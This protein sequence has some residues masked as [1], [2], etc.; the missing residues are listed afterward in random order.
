MKRSFFTIILQYVGGTYIYQ[1]RAASPKAALARW[2]KNVSVEE[3]NLY[4]LERCDLLRALR[5]D[6]NAPVAVDQRT[7]VWC[8]WPSLRDVPALINIVDTINQMEELP[9]SPRFGRQAEQALCR[10]R[11]TARRR[12]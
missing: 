11:K 9:T 4:G 3:L 6:E 5:N 1:T 12:S 2:A 8:T 10:A 7:G